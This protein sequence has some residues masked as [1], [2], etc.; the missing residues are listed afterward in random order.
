MRTRSV[1]SAS[2]L[3]AILV[4]ATACHKGSSFGPGG[5]GDGL[6]DLVEQ[7]RANATQSFLVD[8]ANGGTVSGTGGVRVIFP[9]NAFRTP[10]GGAVSGSVEVRLLEI[11][12][13]GDMIMYDAQTVGL[14]GGQPRLLRSGGAIHVK[15]FQNG[16]ALVLGPQGMEVLMPTNAID[17][18][19]GVFT[20][21]NATPQG[22]LWNQEP[23]QLDSIP[24]E[25]SMFYGFQADSL[26]WIN[27]DYFASYPQTTFVDAVIPTNISMDSVMVWIAFPSENAVMR[28][29]PEGPGAFRSVQVAPVGMPA[30]VVALQRNGT[31]YSSAFTSVTVTNGQQVG[32][33]FQVTDQQTFEAAVNAI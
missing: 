31:V 29:L 23:W 26:Q 13:P 11:L 19:M 12:D 1:L 18:Q 9:S 10:S 28:M 24:V 22:L 16:Q 21:N 25:G 3:V 5:G 4:L 6:R 32:L 17:P 14:D 27:C 15:A 30:V 2:T 7:N 33:S 20:A 8:A